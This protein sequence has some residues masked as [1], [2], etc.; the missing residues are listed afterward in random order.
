MKRSIGSIRNL[1]KFCTAVL[2]SGTRL[3]VRCRVW[4]HRVQYLEPS[5]N[6]F[7]LICLRYVLY[8][9]ENHR[10]WCTLFSEVGGGWKARS[11]GQCMTFR[12]P[13]EIVISGLPRVFQATLAFIVNVFTVWF[14]FIHS[15]GKCALWIACKKWYVAS[16]QSFCCYI[17]MDWR[18]MYDGKPPQE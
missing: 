10:P 13:V 1:F 3:L 15:N 2:C 4:S 18:L 16:V 12:I 5:L 11:Y 17:L 7:R 8:V 14:L 6:P 9:P